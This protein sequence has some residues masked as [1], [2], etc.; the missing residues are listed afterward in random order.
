M[1]AFDASATAVGFLHQVRWALLELLRIGKTDPTA[2]VSVEVFD[3]VAVEDANGKPLKAI[4][5]KHHASP[6]TLTN[7]GADLWKTLRVWLETPP[8]RDPNGPRLYLVTTGKSEPGSIAEKLGTDLITRNPVTAA[9]ELTTV[10]QTSVAEETKKARSTWLGTDQSTRLALLNRVVVVTESAAIGDIEGLLAQELQLTV[11]HEHM[12]LF[13]ERLWGWWDSVAVA[14]LRT[15]DPQ[16]AVAAMDAFARI[17]EIRD[18]FVHGSLPLD[19]A[20]ADPS[21]AD[22]EEHFDKMFVKQ[23]QWVNVHGN[24]LKRAVIN[25]HRAY[26]QTAAWLR[27]S[28]LFNA[29]IDR[30]Q[31]DLV[32]EWRIHF[33]DMCDDLEAEGLN[34]E[35]A[36]RQA[37]TQLFRFI[38]ETNEVHI[39]RNFTEKFYIDGTRHM[40]ADRGELGWHPDFEQRIAD[41]LLNDKAAV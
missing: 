3:D 15:D 37:G 7:A 29:D 5:L 13:I 8:L 2:R 14:M 22:I 28:D 25:Y 21:D 17:Q 39:R 32:D 33:E 19:P 34:T 30:Y 1:A 12:N 36:K 31:R 18:D 9:D 16:T 23:L 40:I 20:L 41:L 6:H 24:N 10:A 35:D 38:R 27:D 26:T 11:R 4:Q